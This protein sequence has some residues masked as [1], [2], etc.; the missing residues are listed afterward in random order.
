MIWSY[1]PYPELLHRQCGG[2]VLQR[3]LDR[4][5]YYTLNLYVHVALKGY[6]SINGEWGAQTVVVNS[7]L[8]QSWP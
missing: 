3:S 1:Y 6:Y 7:L 4:S 8:G 2:L 5:C